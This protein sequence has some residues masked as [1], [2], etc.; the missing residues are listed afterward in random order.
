MQILVEYSLKNIRKLN[1]SINGYQIDKNMIGTSDCN[2]N[3]NKYEYIIKIW[4]SIPRITKIH[5][6]QQRNKTTDKNQHGKSLKI[7][8]MQ[9][10]HK[11]QVIIR[12][13]IKV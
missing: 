7:A 11:K 10:K 3:K 2:S 6:R 13:E 5:I 8:N 1:I 12:S 4:K 9:I